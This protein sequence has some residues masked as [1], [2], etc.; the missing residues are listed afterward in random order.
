[1]S[2]EWFYRRL[3]SLYPKSYLRDYREPMEQAFR[4]QLRVAGSRFGRLKVTIAALAD[5]VRSVPQVH[6]QERKV[7]MKSLKIHVLAL[8][9][10]MVLFL[11]RF[12][13]HSD[14]AGMVVFFTLLFA[15]V[16]AYLQPAWAR[17]WALVGLCVPLAHIVIRPGLVVVEPQPAH[18]ST[19][20]FALIAILMVA[21]GST[22][23]FL[24]TRIR[25]AMLPPGPRPA[26]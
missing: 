21:V 26:A 6:R 14:D 7:P 20:D 3:L 15:F 24:G 4:D 23:S 2:G 16:L 12:E 18:L 1:M 19:V 5:I 25:R 17:L 13:L 22:G 8:F 10:V 9:V 11:G